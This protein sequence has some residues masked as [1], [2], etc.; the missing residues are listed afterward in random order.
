[1]SNAI[2]GPA[3]VDRE[4][5]QNTNMKPRHELGMVFKILGHRRT[6]EREG[7]NLMRG[8]Y[9]KWKTGSSSFEVSS[10]PS[11]NQPLQLADERSETL[12]SK[13]AERQ[14]TASQQQ[15]R[16]RLGRRYTR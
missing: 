12:A 13:T 6:P 11:K 9:Q 16:R 4:D 2:E 5:S 15:K 7:W 8:V 1:M 3:E 14:E 10:R